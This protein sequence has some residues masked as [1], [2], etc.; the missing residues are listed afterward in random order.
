MSAPAAHAI[1]APS[2]ASRWV[3]CPGSIRMS[4][5][6]V[7]PQTDAAA[8]GELAHVVCEAML[9][10]RETP[11][12]A[13]DEMIDGA[14]AYVEY[15]RSKVDVSQLRVEER[16]AGVHPENWGTPD[17]WHLTDTELHVFDYKFGYGVVDPYRNFQ[18]LNYAAGIIGKTPDMMI[19]LHI[20]QPRAYHRNGICRSWSITSDSAF[21]MFDQLA[22]A[23]IEAM[24]DDAKCFTGEHCAHC[25]GRYR[26][27]AL[28]RCAYSI[29][30]RS[31]ESLPLD[32]AAD[33][34]GRLLIQV[35]E[36]KERLEAIE[37]GL[38]Q[39]VL[40]VLRGGAR[41][42]GWHIEVGAG[43]EKWRVPYE[44]V[45]VLGD[46]M[47]IDVRKPGLVTPKQAVKVG[48]PREVVDCYTET[49][50]GKVKVARDDS[51]LSLVFAPQK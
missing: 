2:A 34:M 30:D 1:L 28:L 12:D 50:S 32:I 31:G 23:C 37:S 7:E 36:S 51:Q 41:V 42:P 10:G 14:I 24:R 21:G 15:I 20:I 25:P 8:E 29:I 13:T 16:V 44:E 43:R 40:S 33:V 45:C 9:F 19:H 22:S 6:I 38:E 47:G 46:S 11:A 48:L 3:A 4:A 5:G 39:Q 49:P 18:L 17:A 26:C 35:R 27:P